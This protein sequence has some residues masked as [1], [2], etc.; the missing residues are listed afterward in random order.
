MFDPEW[1]DEHYRE[2]RHKSLTEN[3][4]IEEGFDE[5]VEFNVQQL[6]MIFDEENIDP[7]DYIICYRDGKVVT[8]KEDRHREELESSSYRRFYHRLGRFKSKKNSLPRTRHAFWWLL[9]NCAAHIAIGLVPTK[10]TF[11][12][13]DWTSKKL[14]TP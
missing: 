12:F 11:A 1:L 10:P 3:E 6:F 14:N 7:G 13:H 5:E 8:Q 2:Q 9:H 4:G